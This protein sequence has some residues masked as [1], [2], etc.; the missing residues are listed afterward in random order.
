[1]PPSPTYDL[2]VSY[3]DDD[4]AW[5]EGYLLDALNQASV[6][7]HSEA[8]FSLGVPR[9]IEFERAITQSQRTL[10]VL[11]PAYLINRFS[12][13]ADL[14]A[15]TYG[16][17]TA[18]WPVIPLI[19]RPVSLPSRLSMLT[20]LDATDPADWPTA[21]EQLCQTLQRPVPGPAPKPPCPYPGMVPFSEQ[22]TRHFFGRE[23]EIAELRRRVRHQNYL[24]V[25]G[26]SGSGKSSLVFAG[27]VPELH[28]QQP[29]EW[30][31]KMMRPGRA[32]LEGLAQVFDGTTKPDAGYAE[33][34]SALLVEAPGARRLL[35]VVDQFE[36]LFAQTPRPD[37]AAFIAALTALR[38]IPNCML[39]PTMRADFYEDLMS[40]D[41]WP[42]DAS[43]R[44]EIAPL[45]GTALYD[46][47][48]K[49]AEGLGVYLEAGL[50]ERLLADAADEPGAL[51]LIQ[52]TMSLLWEKMA[53]R[54]LP[55]RAYETLGG[56]ERSGLAVAIA[57]KADAAL[58]NLSS[59]QQSIARRILLRLIQFG[60]GRADTRRQQSATNLQSARDDPV[61]F[62]QTLRH[63]TDNRL[64]TLSSEQDDPD[65]KVDIAHESLITT[66]PQF[67]RWLIE[68]RESE[69]ARRRL[70]GKVAEWVRLGHG[71]G[72]LFDAI[73]L[74]EAERWLESPD[75]ADLGYS[76]ELPM[77]A[78][79]SRAAI[80][81]DEHQR[82]AARTRELVL[83]QQAREAAEARVRE[84]RRNLRRLV[85]LAVL[86]LFALVAASGLGLL[87]NQRTEEARNQQRQAERQ[88]RIAHARA[89]AASAQAQLTF[90][91]ELSLLLAT[92]AISTTHSFQEPIVAQAEDVL[93]QALFSSHIRLTLPHASNASIISVAYSPDGRS[94]ATG[95][96][97]NTLT[98]WDAVTG[99]ARLTLQP[100]SWH[101]CRIVY[102]PD[103][104]F[105]AIYVTNDVV[106]VLESA[107][108]AKRLT[109][110]KSSQWS[111]GCFGNS[112]LIYSPDG[113]SILM[114]GAEGVTVWDAITGQKRMTLSAGGSAASY[115]PDGRT[116]ATI[117]SHGIEIWDAATGAQRQTLPLSEPGTRLHFDVQYSPDGR[118]IL[119][120]GNG[121]AAV[122]DIDTGQQRKEISGYDPAWSPDGRRLI[123]LNA[124]HVATIWDV[125]SWTEDVHL[126]DPD[127][128]LTSVAWNPDGRSVVMGDGRSAKV[129]NTSEEQERLTIAGPHDGKMYVRA[130][131]SPDGQ[132]TLTV[133]DDTVE[134]R[135]AEGGQLRWSARVPSAEFLLSPIGPLESG[136]WSADG[137]FI[138]A[139]GSAQNGD[140][141]NP[142]DGIVK[143]WDAATG[144][145]RWTLQSRADPLTSVACSP[146]GSRIVTG[147]LKVKVWSVTSGQE[148]WALQLPTPRSQSRSVAYSPDGRLIVVGNSDGT[149]Q[150][151][152]A[153]TGQIH[154]PLLGHTQDVTSVA[155]SSDGQSIVTASFDR[156][157]RIWDATSGRPRLVMR[158]HADWVKSAAYSP[159]GENIATASKDGTVRVWDASTGQQRLLFNGGYID[160]ANSA[161]YSSDGRFLVTVAGDGTIRQY[162][163]DIDELLHLA[164]RRVT[165]ELSSDEREQFVLNR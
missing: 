141:G 156:T 23:R 131:Y 71:N 11:S 13:F 8:A 56:D 32:P 135:A 22:D 31:V 157:V 149:A 63:M 113:R 130:Q 87:A 76:N 78:Q 127:D 21:V 3:A 162:L 164:H 80:E 145:E 139:V 75:A 74:L 90:D 88:E 158:G 65:R 138:I 45:R 51:P 15:Q 155:W 60:E 20:A 150:I 2:F 147:G 84:T 12:Q 144:Q 4:R 142:S 33:R 1:M 134:V 93:H 9:I 152:D 47:I 50:L 118:S 115:G 105:L 95:S 153:A 46:A 89:L 99:Q 112:N 58:A 124:E 30:L 10:V 25:I 94:I 154:R 77:L 39:V 132:S 26:P 97:E 5:V 79:A 101:I 54:L 24:F 161:M 27:L 41:L 28:R 128:P 70:E 29:G 102:S 37:Q 66:W 143:L 91:P 163:M 116:I 111:G 62:E 148:L 160:G 151:V 81:A 108:G 68:R 86:L 106:T 53:H 64:L 165:R 100:P 159:N 107:S 126:I 146:D 17:E 43:Q 109:L 48:A 57:T 137:R 122:W 98:V 119:T 14:L 44:L 96:F 121:S 34:V 85:A 123:I 117:G 36:E 136:T 110:G 120:S 104:R 129:W 7:Y 92:Q 103:G 35:L 55:L 6:R 19:L 52:E 125:A 69:Q 49:P 16:V 42:V 83:A 114:A 61:L 67:Q 73:E 72:G 82:E 133:S 140:E 59:L 18:I 40:S 38:Q